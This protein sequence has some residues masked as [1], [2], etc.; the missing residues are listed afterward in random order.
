MFSVVAVSEVAAQIEVF[1][2]PNTVDFN[3]RVFTIPGNGRVSFVATKVKPVDHWEEFPGVNAAYPR[4]SEDFIEGPEAAGYSMEFWATITGPEY[5]TNG[6]I[7]LA[8]AGTPFPSPDTRKVLGA[9]LRIARDNGNWVFSL[10][11]DTTNP[12]DVFTAYAAFPSEFGWINL[13][14]H[15]EYLVESDTFKARLYAD[16]RM[17]RTMTNPV[18]WFAPLGTVPVQNRILVA[19]YTFVE[20]WGTGG[21]GLSDPNL[22]AL[23]ANWLEL[24]QQQRTQIAADL[25]QIK[26]YLATIAQGVGTG[27]GTTFA[28]PTGG[29][30]FDPADAAPALTTGPQAAIDGVG[31]EPPSFVVGGAPSSS[32]SISV[33]GFSFGGTNFPPMSL[34]TSFGMFD[35]F[36]L[37]IHAFMVSFVTIWSMG[38]VFGEFRRG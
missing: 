31:L 32:L 25:L 16:S 13:I 21:G 37:P 19:E 3:L 10:L 5:R 17:Y 33:P 2:S 26:A 23:L 1:A 11:Q 29:E 38:R 22:Y 8:I 30:P 28:P 18:G 24:W 36:R 34:G 7:G 35:D 6:N 27:P 9:N 20:G 12:L 14:R 15:V 4:F